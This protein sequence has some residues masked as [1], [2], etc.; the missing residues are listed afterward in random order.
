MTSLAER[1]AALVG[2]T[3]AD[4]RRLS[5]G[6]LSE[7]IAL[8]LADGRALIAK[9][10]SSNHGATARAEADMLRAISAMGAPAPEVL[11]VADDLLVMAA[12]ASDGRLGGSAW[13]SLA[14]AL[15]RLHVPG[16]NAYGWPVDHAFGKV[17]ILNGRTEDWAEFWAD[18]RLRCHLPHLDAELGRRLEAL[19]DRIGERVPA[20][21]P[22][23]LLH[24][25]LWGGNVLVGANPD[26]VNL[27]DPACYYGDREVDVTMLTLFDHPPQDFFEALGLAAGWRERQPIY[28]L[29]PLLVHL[30]LFGT[31]YR[32]QVTD[33]LD[34][35]G[36]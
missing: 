34:R 5:G 17:A 14:E 15:G 32:A 9:S 29:W 11:G 33:A 21:P 22:S 35:L 13:R 23:A 25:D 26:N 3:L 20:R 16:E 10:F 1:A 24:G 19:A 6:S 8:T 36:A 18:R 28:R 31:G 4:A 30:R 12:V 2:G 7:V 27:I